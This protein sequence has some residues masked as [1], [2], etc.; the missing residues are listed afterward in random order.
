MASLAF[1]V[2]LVAETLLGYTRMLGLHVPLGVLMTAILALLL[3]W[4]GARTR[5]M[6][7]SP[8]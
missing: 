3:V 6:P 8:W 2:V 5:V 7:L 1:L 4:H